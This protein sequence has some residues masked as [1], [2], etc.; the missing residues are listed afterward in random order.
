[1]KLYLVQ[2]GEAVAKDVDPERPL[3]AKGRTDC[4]RMASLLARSG[5]AAGRV[6]HSGRR[7]AAETALLL[8]RVIGPGN[9]AEEAESGLGPKDATDALMRA[10]SDWSAGEDVIVVGHLPFMG[11]MVSHLTT[12]DP[13]A[14]VVAF[15]PGTVVCLAP[16]DEDMAV[17]GPGDWRM[18]WM[19]RPELLG[20]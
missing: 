3:S 20:S 9:A 7:R 17:A 10:I 16:K 13:G 15:T 14:D 19:V 12:G 1:M 5:V 6:V 4:E 18:S 8:S 2:H 11:H